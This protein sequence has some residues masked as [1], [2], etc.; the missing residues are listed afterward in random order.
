MA[1]TR[2]IQINNLIVSHHDLFI[3]NSS[4]LISFQDHHSVLQMCHTTFKIG[5]FV[6][7]ISGVLTVYT[8]VWLS[9]HPAHPGALHRG[10]DQAATGWASSAD[11]EPGT[12]PVRQL[13]H[14]GNDELLFWVWVTFLLFREAHLFRHSDYFRLYS[15]RCSHTS[16]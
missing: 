11:R 5:H 2:W 14:T 6:S 9:G 10:T 4:E 3:S 8:P 16:E 7:L 15:H 12:R 13:R 1:L